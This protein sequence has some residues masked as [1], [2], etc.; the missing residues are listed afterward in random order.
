MLFLLFLFVFT[1]RHAGHTRSMYR[2]PVL[3]GDCAD[4]GSKISS[5]AAAGFYPCETLA[6]L[7]FK[8]TPNNLHL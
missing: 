5:A 3:V 1:V 6:I 2:I 8:I 4:P 7:F